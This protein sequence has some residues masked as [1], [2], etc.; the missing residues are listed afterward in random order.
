MVVLALALQAAMA[1]PCLYGA[2]SLSSS[3]TP[4]MLPPSAH[5]TERSSRDGGW[6]EQGVMFVPLA[7]AGGQMRGALARSGW[8]FEHRVSLAGGGL[9]H[10][11]SFRR[12]GDEI[13]LMLWKISVNRTGFSWG[14]THAGGK[15]HH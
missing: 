5:V 8:L 6:V 3:R 15:V 2:A 9:G 7:S 10:I 1:M 12:N 13:T 4:F 14:R 11:Y